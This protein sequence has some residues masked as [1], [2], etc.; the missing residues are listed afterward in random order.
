MKITRRQLRRLI[1]EAAFTPRRPLDRDALQ[2]TLGIHPD[3]LKSTNLKG[4]PFYEEGKKALFDFI[5]SEAD[6]NWG[7]GFSGAPESIHTIVA[8]GTDAVTSALAWRNNQASITEAHVQLML[9]DLLDDGYIIVS[10]GEV[11]PT[12]EGRAQFSSSFI[13]NL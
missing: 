2:T 10:D 8:N 12:D 7:L 11:L 3:Q 1:A 9:K 6:G 13:D 4:H 5:E